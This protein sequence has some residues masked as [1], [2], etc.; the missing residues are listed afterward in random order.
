MS[1]SW[2]NEF[3]CLPC[4]CHSAELSIES[5]QRHKHHGVSLKRV[6]NT[7]QAASVD[8][9]K[10][11]WEGSRCQGLK[12]ILV[13]FSHISAVTSLIVLVSHWC[14]DKSFSSCFSSWSG[15]TSVFIPWMTSFPTSCVLYSTS[16]FVISI[17]IISLIRAPA[18]PCGQQSYLRASSADGAP[19]GAQGTES[20]R[21]R[22]H[23][24]AGSEQ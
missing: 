1:C 21:Q 15:F 6:G 9:V 18:P 12:L 4:W 23:S 5:S 17:I 2:M 13:S 8:P 22:R 10:D 20:W 19:A 24:S 14:I 3:S 16:A 7:D 11:M